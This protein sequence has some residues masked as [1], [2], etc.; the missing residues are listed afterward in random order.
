MNEKLEQAGIWLVA[1]VSLTIATLDLIGLLG[2]MPWLS[3]RVPTITL[4][5]L[6]IIAGYL[7]LERRNK[8]D[9]I[10]KEIAKLNQHNAELER[11]FSQVNAFI[12]A[13]RKKDH[14]SEIS[15]IYQLRQQGRLTSEYSFVVED[16]QVLNLW[17]DSIAGARRWLAITLYHPRVFVGYRLGKCYSTRN[18]NRTS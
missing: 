4:L 17:R 13:F 18:L 2:A 5:V 14:F 16:N 6:G 10:N 12:D 11:R 3:E 7:G 15:L 9:E 1:I 8:L